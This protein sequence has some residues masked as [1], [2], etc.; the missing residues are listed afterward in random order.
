MPG[1]NE[2]TKYITLKDNIGPC[3]EAAMKY[4]RDLFLDY[5]ANPSLALYL[6]NITMVLLIILLCAAANF[7]TRKIIL[8]L[9]VLFI[10]RNKFK[11]DDMLLDRKVFQRLSHIV[12]AIIIYTSAPVFPS[13]QHL[14]EKGAF[15]Y[16][17]IAAV[18][19]LNAFLNAVNDIYQTYEVSRIRPIRGYIQVAKIILYILGAIVLIS[20]LI[21]QNPLILL[22]GLGALSAVLMLI[23]KDSILGLVAGVQLSAND[24]VRVGDWIEMPKYDAD[25]DVIDIT[26]NTVKVQ[27]WDKTITMVPSYAFISDSFKN[28]RGMQDTGGRR[29]KRSIYID[30]SSIR[31]CTP[32]MIARFRKIHHL[33]AYIERKEQEI[34]A[35]NQERQIDRE[36]VVN[37]RKLTNIGTYRIYIQR[38][39]EHHPQ[40]HKGLT[41]MVRQLA[42]GEHGLPLEIYAFSSD[43]R[44]VYY[45]AIQADIFDHLLAIAP[46]FGLRIFQNPTGHDMQNMFAPAAGDANLQV[47]AL[48]SDG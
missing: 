37:G 27:N 4:I 40:I 35:Y 22:S 34:E 11:W 47:R 10:T 33:T 18:S 44:W 21:G 8:R 46:E 17:F 48:S 3:K 9:I 14:L 29:I 39:L 20:T 41:A 26:L 7:T 13:Y 1:L 25:G 28:W 42:P 23:F 32:E 43:I 5:G 15:V 45:E 6:S 12:P 36:S 31:F 30:A 38:Y 19:V 24:M 16:L 2:S